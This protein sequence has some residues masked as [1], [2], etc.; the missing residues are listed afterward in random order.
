MKVFRVI[1][2]LVFLALPCTV[3]LTGQNTHAAEAKKATSID[4]LA[5]MYDSTGCKECHDVIYKEWEQSIHSRSIFGTGRTAAT[6]KT[7]VAVGLTSW[8]YRA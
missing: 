7:T 6:I 1:A 2:V 5:K 3:L 8:Q 4:E